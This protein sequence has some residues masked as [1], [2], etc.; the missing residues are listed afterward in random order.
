L[1]GAAECPH[2]AAPPVRG[3]RCRHRLPFRSAFLCARTAARS[4]ERAPEPSCLASAVLPPRGFSPIESVPPS[5]ARPNRI[6]FT[7]RSFGIYSLASR[8]EKFL[9]FSLFH[10]C[11]V[12]ALLLICSLFLLYLLRVTLV[13]LPRRLG[14]FLAAACLDWPPW[15]SLIGALPPGNKQLLVLLRS[16]KKHLFP[17]GPQ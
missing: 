17:W 7:P 16:T 14:L 3:L 2:R 9:S 11:L 10:C 1:M 12:S 8:K 6:S 13:T 4:P 15:S 5:A